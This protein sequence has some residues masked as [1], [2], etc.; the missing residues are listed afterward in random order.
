MTDG[1]E[2]G[3]LEVRLRVLGQLDCSWQPCSSAQP[4]LDKSRPLIS[5][6]SLV[7]SNGKCRSEEINV[8]GV[9]G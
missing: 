6:P 9:I 1:S 3:D 4:L 5:P 2:S 8:I 7:S